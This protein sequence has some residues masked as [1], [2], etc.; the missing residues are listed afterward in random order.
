MFSFQ[1]GKVLFGQENALLNVAKKGSSVFRD[2][3]FYI[4]QTWGQYFKENENIL[5]KHYSFLTENSNDESLT[6][7]KK[8]SE[9]DVR[10]QE[11]TL[12]LEDGNIGFKQ[13]ECITDE[14]HILLIILCF[15]YIFRKDKL[16]Y[17]D[18]AKEPG[19]KKDVNKGYSPSTYVENRRFE[20]WQYL[21][22]VPKSVSSYWEANWKDFERVTCDLKEPLPE[23]SFEILKTLSEPY[24]L[25]NENFTK[26]NKNEL[27]TDW[28]ETILLLDN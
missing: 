18:L 10:P 24:R 19:Y 7:M 23:S 17:S 12:W 5:L 1:E 4:Y 13:D 20:N 27:F 11:Q 2:E 22:K 15:V 9:I 16:S 6:L 3:I 26:V 28:V 25:E 8:R 14:T 21:I